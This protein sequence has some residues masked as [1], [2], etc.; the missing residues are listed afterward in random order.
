VQFLNNGNQSAIPFTVSF[1]ADAELTQPIG[2]AVIQ[3]AR[4]CANT[5]YTVTTTWPDLP[6]GVHTFWAKVDS[7]NVIGEFSETDNVISGLVMVNPYQTFLPLTR[8]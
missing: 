6:S 4:G 3:E 1:Y 8:R 5:L 2:S 7:Q